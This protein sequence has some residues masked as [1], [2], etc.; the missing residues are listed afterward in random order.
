ML[1][2]VETAL[3]LQKGTLR[4]EREV[5]RDHGNM[6]APSALFV[7]ER[8]INRGLRGSA[9]LSAMG[10]ALPRASSRLKVRRDGRDGCW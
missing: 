1:D 3:E 10:P 7:L 2:A 8:A 9:L 4:D 5:L 6:S